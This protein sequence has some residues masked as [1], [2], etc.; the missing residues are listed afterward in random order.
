MFLSISSASA[1]KTGPY[2]SLNG[3]AALTNDSAL[4]ESGITGSVGF[5]TGVALSGAV[6]YRF[7]DGFRLEGELGYAQ[8]DIESL[9]VTV[10]QFTASTT[11]V[12]GEVKILS[13]MINGIFD[14]PVEGKLQPYL[15]AGIGMTQADVEIAG[16]TAD[17]TAIGG[18]VGFGINYA[19]SED[20]SVGASYRYFATQDY[21]FSGTEV[22]YSS[23][24]LLFGLTFKM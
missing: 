7:E 2:F 14:F 12:S 6:G 22:D 3:G 8:N 19:I 15:L 18:Q 1:Q 23:H 21:D 11:A 10:G 16:A 4:S 17:D 24:H 13:G 9:S 20:V 5:E